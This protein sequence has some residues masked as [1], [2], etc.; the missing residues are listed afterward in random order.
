MK[1]IST[2]YLIS[3]P[4]TGVDPQ[5]FQFQVKTASGTFGMSFRWDGDNTQWIVY[6]TLPDLTIRQV[7]W[8]PSS[9]SWTAWNDFGCF[10]QTDL[11]TIGQ[12]DLSKCSPYIIVWGR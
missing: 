11:A 12:N 7:G 6:A 4:D 5:V 9:V 8:W 3:M 1:S 10:L 2:A